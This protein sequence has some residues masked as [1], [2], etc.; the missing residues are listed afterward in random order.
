MS[1]RSF[2]GRLFG[3]RPRPAPP[4]GRHSR[5]FAGPSV[6]GAAA[7]LVQQAASADALAAAV[8]ESAAQLPVPEA[9][10]D[11]GPVLAAVAAPAPPPPVGAQPPPP[12]PAWS[13]PAD[14]PVRGA[15]APVT[16]G[17]ADGAS[18]ELAADDPR[19]RTFRAA[20]AALLDAPRG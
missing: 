8:A 1:G 10:P 18:V 16:L 7:S 17:F 2:L 14:A 20:A 13:A 15:D 19:V 3:R 9:I 5:S 11:Q 6:P 4:A 12:L